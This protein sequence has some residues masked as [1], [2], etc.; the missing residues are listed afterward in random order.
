MTDSTRFPIRGMPYR[1]DWSPHHPH[2]LAVRTED[3]R[4]AQERAHIRRSTREASEA[5]QSAADATHMA[6]PEMVARKAA[7]LEAAQRTLAQ[8][9][10]PSPLAVTR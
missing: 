1:L 6:S 7:A 5:A 9:A 3:R 2:N 4:K 10:P 8:L